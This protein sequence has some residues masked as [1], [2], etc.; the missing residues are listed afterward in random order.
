MFFNAKRITQDHAT[1]KLNVLLCS[2]IKS[3]LMTLFDKEKAKDSFL[4]VGAIIVHFGSLRRVEVLLIEAKDAKIEE[5]VNVE[6][7]CETK[8][9]AK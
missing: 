6:F 5:S 8:D 1:S 2:E 3:G 7:P 9:R 4:K